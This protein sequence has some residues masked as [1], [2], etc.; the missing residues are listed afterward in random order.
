MRHFILF[1]AAPVLVLSCSHA[2]P[3]P[4]QTD[5]LP[6]FG[7]PMFDFILVLPPHSTGTLHGILMDGSTN[8][9][10]QTGLKVGLEPQ[11]H[12]MV[13]T[14]YGRGYVYSFKLWSKEASLVPGSLKALS[15]PVER[16]TPCEVVFINQTGEPG[17]IPIKVQFTVQDSFKGDCHSNF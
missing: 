3:R 10:T 14:L 6:E 9:A 11:T 13:G 4:P 7:V 1:V 8:G 15:G 2:P 17:P 5:P 16:V 12:T